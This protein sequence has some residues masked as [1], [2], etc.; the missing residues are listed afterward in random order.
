MGSTP[1]EERAD[2]GR[3]FLAACQRTTRAVAAVPDAR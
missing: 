2:P 3:Y 1:L